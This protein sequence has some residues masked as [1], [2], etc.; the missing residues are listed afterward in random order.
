[1]AASEAVDECR[2]ASFLQFDRAAIAQLAVAADVAALLL[3]V[4]QRAQD[5]DELKAA[6]L[7]ADVN[8]EQE[9]HTAQTRVDAAK[10]QL[11]AAVLETRSL[12]SK[13]ADQERDISAAHSELISLKSRNS[14]LELENQTLSSRMETLESSKQETVVALSRCNEDSAKQ[15]EEYDTLQ[16]RFLD[17][18]REIANLETKIHEYNASEISAKFKEQ[19]L[20]QEIDRLKK[21]NEWLNTELTAKTSE[22]ST[23]RKEKITELSQ[24]QYELESVSAQLSATQQSSNS[25]KQCLED[26]TRKYDV[27]IYE[28]KSLKDQLI[29]QEEGFRSEM[30]SQQRLTELWERSAKEA[31]SR[32]IELEEQIDQTYSKESQEAAKWF[33]KAESE[34]ERADELDRRTA[35]LE[36]TIEN[37]EIQ[38]DQASSNGNSSLALFS[39]TAQALSTSKKVG[40]SMTQLYTEFLSTKSELEHEKR[41]NNR[42]QNDLDNLVSEVESHA[43]RFAAQREEFQQMQVELAEMSGLLD[44]ASQLKEEAERA[45]KALKIEAEDAKRESRLFQ[46]QTRDLSRQVQHLLGELSNLGNST[47]L[48]PAEQDALRQIIESGEDWGSLSDVQLTIT[49]RLVVYR[50]IH[51]LQNQNQQLLKVVR[52]LGSKMEEEEKRHEARLEN[53]ESEAVEKATQALEDMDTEIKRMKVKMESYVRER[54]MFRRMLVN[55]GNGIPQAQESTNGA[56]PRSEQSEQDYP[57]IIRELQSQLDACRSEMGTDNKTLRDQIRQLTDERSQFHVETLKSKSQLDLLTERYNILTNTYEMTKNE[58]EEIKKRNLHQQEIIAKQDSRTQQNV[59]DLIDTNSLAESLKTETLNLKSEI[60]LL[61]S[62]ENRLVEDNHNLVAERGRLN[63]L[64]SSLQSMQNDHERIDSDQRRRN[65]RQ[66]ENFEAEIKSLKAKINEER[67][68]AKQINL[69]REFETKEYNEK[70]EKVNFEFAS[71]REKFIATKTSEEHLYSR[72]E[73]LTILLKSAEDKV[74]VFLY[75]RQGEGNMDT[76]VSE[77]ERLQVEVSELK[78]DLKF[79]QTE[80]KDAKVHE[81]E[82]QR[83]AAAAEDTLE[84]FTATHDE[85]KAQMEKEASQRNAEITRLEEK[86]NMYTEELNKSNQELSQ[87]RLQQESK[88][89]ELEESRKILEQELSAT[90]NELVQASE[91]RKALQEDLQKV[92][93]IAREAQTNYDRELIKHAEAARSLSQLR[94]DKSALELQSRTLNKE[95]ELFKNNS[96]NAE[97]LWAVQKERFEREIEELRTR[98]SDLVTQNALLHSQLE[99]VTSQAFKIRQSA[100]VVVDSDSTP[101]DKPLEELREIVRFLRKEKEIVDCQYELCLQESKRFRQQIE[102]T[103]RSLEETRS[104]LEKERQQAAESNQSSARHQELLEKVNESNVLRE[105][106]ASLRA[107]NAQYAKVVQES[108]SRIEILTLQLHPL[109]ERQG[110]MEAELEAKEQ[111]I[112][113]LKEDCDRWKNRTNA[114]LQ[115]YDRID[116]AELQEIK[117]KLAAAII[118]RDEKTSSLEKF[119]KEVESL[120]VEHENKLNNIVAGWKK[121]VEKLMTQSKDKM[122]ALRK[123]HADD[124]EQALVNLATELNTLRES[125]TQIQQEIVIIRQERDEAIRQVQDASAKAS[126]ENNTEASTALLK[127]VER[128]VQESAQKEEEFN[129]AIAQRDQELVSARTAESNVRKQALKMKDQLLAAKKQIAESEA[130]RTGPSQAATTESVEEEV[131]KRLAET[132]Q[133]A[134]VDVEALVQSR[135]ETIRVEFEEEKANAVAEAIGQALSQ[136]NSVHETAIDMESAVLERIKQEQ[137]KWEESAAAREAELALHYSQ[138][139]EQI[140]EK[141]R[142]AL[143]THVEGIVAKRVEQIQAQ[144]IA[145]RQ[146]EIQQAVEASLAAKTIEFENEIA[147]RNKAAVENAQKEWDLRSKVTNSRK[148]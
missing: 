84:N 30:S 2:L 86:I 24:L 17:A 122:S 148:E 11:D 114:I 121:R 95:L 50:N 75:R 18:R 116:P 127:E 136:V 68:E 99:H 143:K 87:V 120:N 62:I 54:D 5:F 141:G 70:L 117:D 46:Q 8:F 115:K 126:A 64:L 101:H 102:H 96:A 42:I 112:V 79:A 139:M 67:D 31:R 20:Q 103:T 27:S 147:E 14:S 131:A 72:V 142:S 130:A 111:Q 107:E 105:S 137:S 3:R 108:Q 74:S 110:E 76:E 104:T 32:V 51:E 43:P 94:D 113:L 97:S 80:L 48:T 100:Q 4:Q 9:M 81:M 28:T 13:T 7:V 10:A 138:E 119:N 16:T 60:Q 39:P 89:R 6:K 58:I 66:V 45:A 12:R 82:Y 29:E 124:K 34:K 37:L 132:S 106:N 129:F 109:R 55:N 47:P 85:F 135:I 22:F 133:D 93:G 38:A 26:C 71:T 146:E 123:D 90:K 92:H 41:K 36:T 40:M 91:T 57:R 73:E 134:S 15:Q 59:A 53:L 65:E 98:C 69:R 49:E 125:H 35:E 88:R 144:D 44:E 118:E 61:K 78:K 63:G 145:K 33:A 52:D 1:M 21:N 19:S 140:R 128:L 83:I 25:F 23:F 56:T 77:V